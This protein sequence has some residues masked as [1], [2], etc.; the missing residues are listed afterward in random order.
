MEGNQKT[1]PALG[2]IL[3]QGFRLLRLV[4]RGTQHAALVKWARCRGLAQHQKRPSRPG[5]AAHRGCPHRDHRAHP[6]QW[7]GA[8]GPFSVAGRANSA[9]SWA[10]LSPCTVGSS[11]FIFQLF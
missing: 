7:H 8:H 2:R 9:G 5:H 10:K 11:S 1:I 4:A 6:C 3:A